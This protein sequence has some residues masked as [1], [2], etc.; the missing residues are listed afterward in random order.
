MQNEVKFLV[1]K[2]QAESAFADFSQKARLFRHL[3]TTSFNNRFHQTLS[4]TDCHS[5]V[6]HEMSTN[7]C[8]DDELVRTRFE[9]IDINL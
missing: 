1:Q 2:A 5:F 7:D 9:I 4:F 3:I 6:L 8:V